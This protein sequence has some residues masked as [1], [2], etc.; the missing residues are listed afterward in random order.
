MLICL[1]ST[2]VSSRV[3]R[4]VRYIYS[5]QSKMR[6]LGATLLTYRTCEDMWL[7]LVSQRYYSNVLTPRPTLQS[8]VRACTLMLPICPMSRP[9]VSARNALQLTS[10]WSGRALV[11][12]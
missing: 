8:T 10:M 7:S 1:V 4:P 2:E 12:Q 3:K 9:W 11:H 5:I 6:R